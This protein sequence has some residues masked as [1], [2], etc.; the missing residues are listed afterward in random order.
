MKSITLKSL[1]GL[2]LVALSATPAFAEPLQYICINELQRNGEM[3]TV[4]YVSEPGIP[5][6]VW[7]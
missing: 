1:L 3:V 4:C 7:A 2:S 5:P 6:I